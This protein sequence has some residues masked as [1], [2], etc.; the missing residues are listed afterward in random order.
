MKTIVTPQMVSDLRAGITAEMTMRDRVFRSTP[1]TRA[2]KTDECRAWLKTIDAM[3]ATLKA[4][5]LITDL[6]PVLFDS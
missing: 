5:N 6:Q 3:E 4:H 1:T 2:K